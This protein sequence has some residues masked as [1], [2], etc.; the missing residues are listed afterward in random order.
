[1]LAAGRAGLGPVSFAPTREAVLQ[2]QRTAGNAAVTKLVVQRGRSKT[3]HGLTED[4]RKDLPAAADA[5]ALLAENKALYAKKAAGTITA[6]ETKR[7]VELDRLLGIRRRADEE[8]TLSRNG[9]KGGLAAWFADVKPVTF[10]GRTFETHKLMAERLKK[11][12]D[13]LAKQ[14][15]PKDGWIT[16]ANSLREPGQGLH[17]LGLAVDLNA[18]T[19]PW[20]INPKAAGASS[21]EASARSSA[22]AKIIDNAVLLLRAKDATEADLQSRPAAT[23]DRADRVAASYDKLRAASDDLREYFTLDKPEC[24]ERL[25]DLV[26]VLGAKSSKSAE[27]WVKQIK[28]DRKVLEQHAAAKNWKSPTSG[29]LDLDKRLVKAMTDDS[30]GGMA[31][32]GDATIASGRDIMH[33]DLRNVGP[34]HSIFNSWTGATTYLGSG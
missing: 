24:A 22:I 18:G 29:F 16:D 6:E 30:A 4:E 14:T 8:E 12:E 25:Q 1:V 28:S 10:L 32:L 15:P 7:M 11:A 26:R 23:P 27:D 2:L 19:N 31:W 5:P 20:L 13:A 34:V 3:E 33:F 17:S 21:Y 9:V